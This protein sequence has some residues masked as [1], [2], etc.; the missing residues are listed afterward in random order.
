MAMGQ[1]EISGGGQRVGWVDIAKGICIVFVVML[2][3]V[4]GVEIA[5]GEEGW[6]HQVVSFARP[7]RMPDFFLISG[8]FLGLVIDRPWLRY[9]D[10]KVVHFAYFYVLWL[11]IQ[12]AFKA[13]GMALEQGWTHALDTYLSAFVQPFGTLWFIYL[14][15]LFFVLTRLVKTLPVWAVFAAAALFEV[16]PVH[17]G[18]IIIDEFCGRYVYFFAGYAFAPRIFA[19]ASWAAAKPA[20]TFALLGLWAVANAMLVFTPAP[21]TLVEYLQADLGFTGATHGY[22]ELPFISLVLGFTGAFAVVA[23]AALMSRLPYIDGIRWLGAHSIVVYL[24]FFLP[25]A[26]TRAVLVKSGIITDPGTAGAL[27]TAAAVI[28]PVALYGVTNWCGYGRFLFER[29]TWA[30]IDTRIV[31]ARSVPAG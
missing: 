11:T 24:A 30:G 21:E 15:P 13:P 23:V 25:M 31:S 27:V 4:L 16:L 14:L 19:V 20:T 28:G 7:F 9:V 12:F 2:H 6:M 29:P 3:S 1:G 17:T 8:L 10:R 5:M 22:S 26:A 18:S